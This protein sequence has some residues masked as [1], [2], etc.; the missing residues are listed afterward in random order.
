[1][2]P[3]DRDPQPELSLVRWLQ[4]APWQGDFYQLLR[5]LDLRPEAVTGRRAAPR[6]AAPATASSLPARR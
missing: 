5:R 6:A 3:E 2:A 1:M 4:D